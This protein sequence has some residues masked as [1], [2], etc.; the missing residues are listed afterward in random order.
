[1]TFTAQ[2]DF[3]ADFLSNTQKAQQEAAKVTLFVLKR[4]FVLCGGSSAVSGREVDYFTA[5]TARSCKLLL[6][7]LEEQLLGELDCALFLSVGR[8]E[9]PSVSSCTRLTAGVSGTTELFALPWR[10]GDPIGN[11]PQFHF[12]HQMVRRVQLD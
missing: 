6:L 5:R 10:L 3:E 7:S 9:E 2:P 1:M 8:H 11:E 4:V 12:W